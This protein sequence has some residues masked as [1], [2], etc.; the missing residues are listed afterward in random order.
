M[1]RIASMLLFTFIVSWQ[2]PAQKQ[3]KKT[4]TLTIELVFASLLLT[5]NKMSTLLFSVL[6]MLSPLHSTKGRA[7]FSKNLNEIL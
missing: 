7:V 1:F 5:L 4:R 2:K 6:S 3:E